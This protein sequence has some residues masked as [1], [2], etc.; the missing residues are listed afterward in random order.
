MHKE[1]TKF[2]R[3]VKLETRSSELVT[4]MNF[5]FRSGKKVFSFQSQLTVLQ[6]NNRTIYQ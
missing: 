1:C 5:D 3:E 2:H 4:Q 6:F